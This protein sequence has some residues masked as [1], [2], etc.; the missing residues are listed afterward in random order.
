MLVIKAFQKA[1]YLIF[2]VFEWGWPCE[3][4]FNASGGLYIRDF[5]WTFFQT[6]AFEPNHNAVPCLTWEW[7]CSC[8]FTN[9]WVKE[10]M[11][12]SARVPKSGLIT[13]DG[14]NKLIIEIEILD[15]TFVHNRADLEWINFV[16][17]SPCTT[18]N[19]L[20]IK[21]ANPLR[22]PSHI[23]SKSLCEDISWLRSRNGHFHEDFW[24]TTILKWSD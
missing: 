11:E 15:G 9:T 1:V 7:C 17:F 5:R 22:N 8:F 19:E 18:I 20:I 3:I 2:H 16:L 13:N 24:I 12:M 4:K 10:E 21:W 14:T 6:M 23:K